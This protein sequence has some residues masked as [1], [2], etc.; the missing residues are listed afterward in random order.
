MG[1]R[2][3]PGSHNT[4]AASTIFSSKI[5]PSVGVPYLRQIQLVTKETTEERRAEGR[6]KTFMERYKE[7]LL[8]L[9]DPRSIRAQ[10]VATNLIRA[11]KV[12]LRLEKECKVNGQSCE[13]GDFREY[14][15][16]CEWERDNV[17]HLNS[18][19]YEGGDL[20]SDHELLWKPG[21]KHLDGKDWEVYV[22]DCPDEE[23]ALH[24]C[25]FS[26]FNKRIVIPRGLLDSLKSDAELAFFIGHEV[27][28]AYCG[29]TC[30]KNLYKVL[31]E[32]L[33]SSHS[34]EREANHIGLMLM[35]SAGYDPQTV[36]G[37]LEKSGQTF[38]KNLL[39][40]AEK[41][42][43][44]FAVFKKVKDYM[45]LRSMIYRRMLD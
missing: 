11:M 16:R 37:I 41:A 7:D 30:S 22:L 26:H 8:P 9:S 38:N 39:K 33:L 34:N 20:L 6:W 36:I 35:A 31:L 4:I 5:V 13:D 44:V 40:E 29:S 45:N 24:F 43:E 10:S 25:H 2:F 23:D 42:K 14:S 1:S 27:D 21:T 15:V 12:G 3:M 17:D 19:K 28:W 18:F 32:Y